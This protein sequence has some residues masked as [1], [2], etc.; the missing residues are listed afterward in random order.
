[1]KKVILAAILFCATL[2]FA[3]NSSVFKNFVSVQGDKLMDEN[4][5][6]KFISFNVPCLHYNEDQMAFTQTNPWSLTNE[7]EI[8]DALEAVRQMGGQVVRIYTLSVRSKDEDPNIIRHITSLGQFN[9]DA[10]KPLDYIL[11]TANKKGIRVII[12]FIDN[13]K[14]WGGIPAM[15]ES[16][17]KNFSDFWTDEQLFEDYKQIVSFLVNRTNTITGVKYKDDKAILAW[18]TGNELESTPQWVSKAAAFI[19]SIDKNHL[20]ID[21][22]HTSIL[23]DSS[24]ENADI[25]IVTTHHYSQNPKETIDQINKNTQKSKGKKP[26]FIGEFGFIPTGDVNEILD[27]VLKNDIA[28]AMIWSLRFRSAQGGFYWHSEHHSDNLLKAYH[29]PGF[30]SGKPYDEAN[31]FSLMRDRAFKIRG[32]PVPALEIPQRPVLLD[33]TDNSQISWQGS[34]GAQ[35]YIIERAETKTGKWLVIAKDIDDAAVQYR[36]L[37][38]DT[39]ATIGKSYYYRVRAKNSAGVSKPSNAVGPVYAVYKSLI[40]ELGDLNKIYKHKG[41][42]AV[43]ETEARKCKEDI[44]RLHGRS[45]SYIIYKTDEPVRSFK[46]YAFFENKVSDFKISGSLDGDKFAKLEFD[47]RSYSIDKGSYGYYTPVLYEGALSAAQNYKYLKIEYTAPAQIGR[48]EIK[49]GKHL[50]VSNH[51]TSPIGF[52]KGFTWGWTGWRG[53]YLGDKPKD[54][55]KKLAQTGSDWVCISFGAEMAT[56][57]EPPIFWGDSYERMATDNEIRRA[58]KLARKN[59]LK[60]ILKPVVN[61][62]DGTWRAFI[63]FD[64]PDGKKDIAKWDKWWSDFRAF[65]LHYAKIAEETGCEMYCLGCEMISTEDFDIKWRNLITDVKQVYAGPITYNT[66]HGREDKIVWWDAVDVISMS[67]YYPVG[68]DDVPAD[69]KNDLSNVPASDRSLAAMKK[70]WLPIKQRLQKISQ[71][72][73][74]PIF[75]IELGLCNA[76]G[77]SVAPWTH[78]DPNMVYNAQEQKDFYQSVFETFWDEPWFMGFTWWAW[79]SELYTL[80][81]AKTNIGFCVYGKPAEELVKQWYKKNR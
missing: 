7:F 69:L 73:D 31:L 44:N 17:G 22:Y 18:E 9:E 77:S 47:N 58:I 71:K 59:N 66:N 55:M 8:A 16:R 11:A 33:I 27:A 46:I 1:M 12:P 53:Q 41:G 29:G 70:R 15:A 72:F 79:P 36:P 24:L 26:Y 14:W 61:V 6:L 78:E 81:E 35:S 48:I 76:G 68:D 39:N 34:A 60:I 4:G 67:A 45:G 5:Q 43:K 37:F 64:T 2:T 57:N 25:D 3:A 20:V 54:S 40:D 62:Y 51:T 30:D 28:G 65:L 80:E 19:K 32:L 49:Y 50:S 75:F 21:G 23:R 42:L 38:A 63:K 52:V 74:R 13:W 10:F 56:P